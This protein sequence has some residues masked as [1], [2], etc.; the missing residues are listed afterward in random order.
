VDPLLTS[1]RSQNHEERFF[2]A[3]A[4]NKSALRSSHAVPFRTVLL[5]SIFVPGGDRSALAASTQDTVRDCAGIVRGSK[6]IPEQAIPRRALRDA[7]RV[8]VPRVLKGGLVVIGRI[9]EGVVI[10][11]LPGRDWVH[12]SSIALGGEQ[13]LAS[14]SGA[15]SPIFYRLLTPGRWRPLRRAAPCSWGAP[16]SIAAGSVGRARPPPRTALG[17]QDAAPPVKNAWIM[18]TDVASVLYSGQSNFYHEGP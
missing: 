18:E 6:T 17:A 7:K 3:D 10:A 12:Q 9:G 15:G 8:T 4:A 13:G 1:R 2:Y 14:Q 5:I 16:L 11:R